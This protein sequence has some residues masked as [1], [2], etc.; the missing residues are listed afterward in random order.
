MGATAG[1]GASKDILVV[2][3]NQFEL[4]KSC[5]NSIRE[6]TDNYC[7][8]VWDNNSTDET[9][10]FLIK[11]MQEIEAEDSPNH[12]QYISVDYNAGFI[13]PNNELA[14]WCKSDYTILLNSDTLV[15]PDWDNV[16][17]GFLKN[18]PD[19]K[20][21]GYTGGCLN[22]NGEG[23]AEF[24]G[25]TGFLGY[26]IDYISGF[27]SCFSHETLK[28]FGLFNDNLKFAYGEDADF[29]LRLK[30]KGY[31]IYAAHPQLVWHKGNAT[32]TEVKKEGKVDLRATFEHNHNYIR[33][34]W[35]HY[36]ENKR[37][38]LDGST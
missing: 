31:K 17:I 4:V 22:E 33:K 38:L 11:M 35:K 19:V 8:Y 13:K 1:K 29:S 2:V 6:N 18:H 5:F 21:V 30:E 28:E 34:R 25:E 36:L 37:A 10:E 3:H 27:C 20:Q 32:V 14:K 23:G 26:K 7:L 15:F 24:K 12:M 16:L 9:P